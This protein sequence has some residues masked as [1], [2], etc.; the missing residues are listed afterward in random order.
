M[1]NIS[2]R[3][4]LFAFV[5]LTVAAPASAYNLV[6]TSW[7]VN[8]IFHPSCS[9]SVTDHIADFAIPGGTGTGRLVSRF[10]QNADGRWSYRY[11]L[12]MTNAGGI[13][14][15]PYADQLAIV[16]LGTLRRYDFNSDGIATDEVYNITSGATG[17]QPLTSAFLSGSWSYFVW[18]GRV[19]GGFSPGEGETSYWFGMVSDRTPVLRTV[20]VHLDSGWVS[21]QGYAP[22]L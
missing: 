3:L 21:M 2:L 6:N 12:K 15:V 1:T 10:F 13:T 4:A 16:S 14:H 19:Y 11:Q 9:V 7:T 22:S 8:C 18:G 17:T 5:A 20:W